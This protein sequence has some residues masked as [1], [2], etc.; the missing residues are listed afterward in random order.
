MDLTSEQYSKFLK[1][2]KVIAGVHAQDIL[3]DALIL[4]DGKQMED[5]DSY[6]FITM[7]NRYINF[8]KE[9]KK[10]LHEPIIEYYE[11]DTPSI[12]YLNQVLLELENEG[13]TN[14]VS[15]FKESNFGSNMTTAAKRIGRSYGYVFYKCKFIKEEIKKRYNN[16]H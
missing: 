16:E 14:E 10:H 11:T 7:R 13:F 6:I 2:A 3:H 1:M 5:I 12:H 9:E 4:I 8:L 15:I